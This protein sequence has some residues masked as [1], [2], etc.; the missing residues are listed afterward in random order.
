MFR[1]DGSDMRVLT[2]A[3]G[4]DVEP[5]WSPDGTKIAFL[6]SPNFGGGRLHIIDVLKGEEIALPNPI[7][8]YG[9][10][11]W[12]P[13]GNKLLG[14]LKGQAPRRLG[15]V[16]LSTGEVT[17]IDVGGEDPRRQRMV[18]ALSPDGAEILYA[19]HA[20]IP[21]EQGG[22]NGPQ[23]IVWRCQADG[24]DN[25]RAFEWPARIYD[26]TI[27]SDAESLF[28]VTD[29]GTA[30]NDI[31]KV[32]L[33]GS[34]LRG[35]TKLTYGQ[36][37][38]ER[39]SMR[40]DRL[41]FTT[42]RT[43]TTE[44]MLR[45]MDNGFQFPLSILEPDYDGELRIRIADGA[46]TRVSVKRK[47][48]KHFSPPG[49]MYRV[50]GTTGHFYTSGCEF[51]LPSGDYEILATRGPEYRPTKLETI[52]GEVQ[53]DMER[54]INLGE[55]GWYSGENHVHANYGYGE[56]YNTPAT[57]LRQCQGED[58]QHLQRGH[59]QL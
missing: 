15:W 46:M 19:M 17:E 5:S 35:A 51:E 10:I 50:T 16:D 47:G 57:I 23:A 29:R 52:G 21:G 6:R 11:W 1:S 24:S 26:M 49:S 22:N 31:W 41:V 55:R 39:P 7:H 48:G 28:V 2:T 8:G 33:E 32:P 30:H 3:E 25:R 37:D 40:G 43:G 44:V 12:Q 4:W 18:W 54:W 56:W 45:R 53:I 27:S 13:D 38:E 9:K 36:S 59:R 58:P 20:D 42:N 34:P 14:T